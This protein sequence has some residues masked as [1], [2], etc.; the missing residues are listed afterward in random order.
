MATITLEKKGADLL[1]TKGGVASSVRISLFDIE[2][3]FNQPTNTLAFL[4]SGSVIDFNNDTVTGLADAEA[5]GDQIGVWI[6]EAN[7]G[8]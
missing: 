5:V 8:V 4:Q 2:I 1:Y 6:K 7:T 3:R